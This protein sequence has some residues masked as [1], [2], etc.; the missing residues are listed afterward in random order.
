LNPI[1]YFQTL[2]NPPV[3]EVFLNDFLN[4]LLVDIG[5]PHCFRIDDEHRASVATIKATGLIDPHLAFPF[6]FELANT[7]F[8]V[9]LQLAGAQ[10]VATG[11]TRCPLIAAEKHVMLEITHAQDSLLCRIFTVISIF[12]SFVGA[13][14]NLLEKRAH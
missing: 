3:H 14:F 11:F 12:V 4:V 8:G 13:D 2:D 1:L 6:E 5:V 10:R 9:G 7:I